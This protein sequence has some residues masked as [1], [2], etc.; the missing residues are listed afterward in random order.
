[1]A[2]AAAMEYV[3]LNTTIPVPKVHFAFCHGDSG[4]IIMDFINGET[5]DNA[6]F[7]CSEDQLLTIAGQLKDF[8]GQLR[9]LGGN[10]TTSMGSWPS[11]PFR[12]VYFEDS[13]PPHEFRTMDEF[14]DYWV[15]RCP[16]GDSDAPELD[17]STA[18]NEVV[19]T[20]GDLASRNIIIKDGVIAAILDWETFG[21]YPSFWE[22]T[23]VYRGAWHRSWIKALPPGLGEKPKPGRYYSYLIS[24]ATKTRY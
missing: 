2:E 1:M 17:H 8:I 14:R 19:L 9:K 16:T 18:V 13:P 10:Q 20:H 21:W 4:Y 5:L 3:R 22:Y 7:N 12:N 24:E 23:F 6:Q 15:Q 11:G